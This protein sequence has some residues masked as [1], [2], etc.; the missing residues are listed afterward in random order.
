MSLKIRRGLAADRTSITPSVGEF[1]YT[2]DTKQVY[3]G[4]GTTAGGNPISISGVAWGSITGTLIAQ[5]DLTAYLSSNYYPLSSNP[6]GYLTS[7]ALIPYLLAT[8]AASTYEPIITAGTVSQYWRGDKTWQ[9][10]PTIPTVTPS[11]LTKTDDTNVTITLGGSPSTA[12]LAA[13]S[14]TVGWTGTL[15]DSRIASAATWNAKQNAL[16]GTGFVVST[17]GVISYDTSVYTPTSRNLTINGTTYDL[18][19]DRSWT[20]TAS[21]KSIN[22]VSINTSAGSASSTDYVYLASGT[23]NITLPTAVGN[24]NLYTIKN[25]GTGVIT[26]DTTSSQTIDGSL[27]APIIV[28]YLSLT[29]ISDGANWNII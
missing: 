8:T 25:V 24:Q 4:D 17:A 13:T 19:A 20:I 16:S 28:Q 15:A 2:T 6:A 18:S 5:T 11:A 29:I 22:V 27:T 3:I 14:L 23:I 21:G 1:L 12:L 26:V 10:F 9:T 7:S